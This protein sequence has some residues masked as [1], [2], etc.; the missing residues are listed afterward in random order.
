VTRE[1]GNYYQVRNVHGRVVRAYCGGGCLAE[2]VAAKDEL[3]RLRRV[4]R[5]LA[6]R[7]QRGETETLDAQV[8]AVNHLADLFAQAALIVAGYHQHDR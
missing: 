2:L 1:R 5:R 7:Q 4:S 3:E 8:S 6:E